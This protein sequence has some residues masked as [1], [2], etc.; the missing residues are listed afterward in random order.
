MSHAAIRT[1]QDAEDLVRGCTLLGTGGGGGPQRGLEL[2]VGAVSRA[3]AVSWVDPVVIPDD[4]WTV[5]LFYMGSIAPPGEDVPRRLKELNMEVRVEKELCRAFAELAAYAGVRPQYVVAAEMGGLNTAAPIDA[6]VELGLQV[7]NGDYGG[8]A[9]PEITQSCV[10]VTGHEVCPLAFCDYAGSVTIVKSAPSYKM[11]E[12]I[13]KLVS[14][15]SFGLV[16]SAGFLLRG[17][18]MKQAVIPGTLQLALELGWTMRQARERGQDPAAA[19]AGFLDGWLLFRGRVAQKEWENREGYMYGWYR[20]AGSGEFTG[21]TLKVWFKNEN[22][23]TWLDD[24]PYVT[25]PDLICSVLEPEGEP[26]T[27][28]EI[29]VGQELAIVG[30]RSHPRYRSPEGLAVLAPQHFGFELPY[31]PIEEVVG[32]P[33]WST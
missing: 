4:A 5:C 1:R 14:A 17:R 18:D 8:R 6:A 19:A 20:L 9:I 3:G 23:V 7:V 32:R 21:R 12:R 13:G 31:V 15:A 30:A 28:S 33:G 26:I 22:Q 24:E 29:A 27:N 25:S 10:A 11:V 2:L 16:G